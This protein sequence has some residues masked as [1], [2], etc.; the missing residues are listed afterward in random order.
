MGG[1]WVDT[2]EVQEQP[3]QALHLH[4]A[5]WGLTVTALWQTR[6]TGAATLEQ[7]ILAYEK[8]MVLMPLG[9]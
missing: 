2:F 8:S 9:W 7:T 4:N 3:G 6:H 1:A 5:H